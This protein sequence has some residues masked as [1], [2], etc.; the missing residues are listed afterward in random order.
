MI[1]QYVRYMVRLESAS[2]FTVEKHLTPSADSQMT[3]K[4]SNHCFQ[5]LAQWEQEVTSCQAGFEASR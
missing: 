3:S 2:P 5:M 4:V 1:L